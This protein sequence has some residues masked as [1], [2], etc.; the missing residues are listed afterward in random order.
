[1]TLSVFVFVCARGSLCVYLILY[2]LWMVRLGTSSIAQTIVHSPPPPPPR[3]SLSF[4]HPVTKGADHHRQIGAL[5][6]PS[7]FRALSID[8]SSVCDVM[9][10][11][12]LSTER[13]PDLLQT[14]V[15]ERYAGRHS[16]VR[17]VHCSRWG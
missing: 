8:S 11:R 13:G 9:R 1:M 10:K 5:G 6:E 16:A 4:Q 3:P 17:H 7:S 14:R 15:S 2:T 12:V